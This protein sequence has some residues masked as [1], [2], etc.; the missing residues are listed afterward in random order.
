HVLGIDDRRRDRAVGPDAV[1]F[2]V[3]EPYRQLAALLLDLVLD[4]GVVQRGGDAVARRPLHRQLAVGALAVH[5]VDGIAGVLRT[6]VDAVGAGTV[7]DPVVVGLARLRQ[8]VPTVGVV[9]VERGPAVGHRGLVVAGV[10][11][12]VAGADGDAELPVGVGVAE[13]AR[14]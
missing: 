12:L 1:A 14:Q 5:A 9:A 10:A 3:V 11:L 6:R 8:P 7:L 2:A 13:D 4:V